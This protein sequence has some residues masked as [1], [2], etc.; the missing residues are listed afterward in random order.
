MTQHSVVDVSGKSHTVKTSQKAKNVSVNVF[1]ATRQYEI[2][3]ICSTNVQR[4]QQN[5]SC[6]ALN[7]LSLLTTMPFLPSDGWKLQVM[8]LVSNDQNM[9]LTVILSELAMR[10]KV[11]SYPL[12]KVN[13][14]HPKYQV[15]TIL[16]IDLSFFIFFFFFPSKNI[17]HLPF[18]LIK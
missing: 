6:G 9:K 13:I 16:I 15:P 2:C 10:A 3:N 8:N 12:K 4:G 1:S 11:I 17:K 18:Q 14:V 7:P 5:K